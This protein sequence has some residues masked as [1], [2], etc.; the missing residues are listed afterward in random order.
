[1]GI[2]LCKMHY[3]SA[4]MR[5]CS[6]QCLPHWVLPGLFKLDA[7]LTTNQLSGMQFSK[8][9]GNR[10]WCGTLQQG[11]SSVWCWGVSL[12]MPPRGSL[13]ARSSSWGAAFVFVFCKQ[14][15]WLG[16]ADLHSEQGLSCYVSS[17]PIC[18]V[19]K[20]SPGSR[21]M[22]S[23]FAVGTRLQRQLG[24]ALKW[25]PIPRSLPCGFSQVV[26]ESTTCCTSKV[27]NLGWWCWGGVCHT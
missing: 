14:R 13:W 21:W 9:F 22:L 17:D 25:K 2:A 24:S 16:G 18:H 1:M 5:A 10:L 23:G 7:F 15:D 20:E 4:W 26:E 3:C 6:E 19:P 11:G 12:I 8:S 27:L